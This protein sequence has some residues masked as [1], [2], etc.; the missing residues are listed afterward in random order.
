ML[1]PLLV[2]VLREGAAPGPL[3]RRYDRVRRRAFGVAARRAVRGMWLGTRT[4]RVASEL[5]SAFLARILLQPPL[6]D[7]LPAHFAMWTIPGVQ[8]TA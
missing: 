6:R 5:R 2:S 3:L 4:G 1:A 8:V 7:R